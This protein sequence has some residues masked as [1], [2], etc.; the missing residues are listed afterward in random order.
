[1][2]R[3]VAVVFASVVLTSCSPVHES[4]PHDT[5]YPDAPT[6]QSAADANTKTFNEHSFDK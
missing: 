1:M 2:M 6:M 3:T 4:A 5:K